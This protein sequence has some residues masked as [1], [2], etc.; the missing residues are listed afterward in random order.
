[1]IGAQTNAESPRSTHSRGVMSLRFMAPLIALL[2]LGGCAGAKYPNYYT[3]NIPD[4]VS[5]S[6][7]AAPVPGTVMVREFRAPAYLTQG[8]I[9]Y[10]P[11]SEQIA[12][13]TYHHW[14]EDPRKTVTAAVV[15]DLRQTFKSAELY[16]G[17]GDAEFLLTGTLDRLEELDNG[18]SVSVDVGISATLR[19]LKTGDVIWSGTSSKTSAVEQRSVPGVVAATS[20]ELSEAADA[21]VTALQNELSRDTQSSR[22]RP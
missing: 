2:A 8:P 18:R 17:R 21:I 14:A 12:F 10:R 20:R 7:R 4:P 16:D 19:N 1:M 9:V 15:R 22:L 5:A 11:E 3:L 6:R 13:Y